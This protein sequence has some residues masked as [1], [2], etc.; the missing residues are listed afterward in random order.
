VSM[1]FRLNA[2]VVCPL[3]AVGSFTPLRDRH[4]AKL[5]S[6]CLSWALAAA[7]LAREAVAGWAVG[8]VA[9]RVVLEALDECVEPPGGGLVVVG[10]VGAALVVAGFPGALEDVLDPLPH[11]ASVTAASRQAAV[12]V[13]L[14]CAAAGSPFALLLGV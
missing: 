10:A 4:A 13:V 11:A 3:L 2:V 5:D 14:M 1:P 7:V 9:G 8:P 12:A 6:A